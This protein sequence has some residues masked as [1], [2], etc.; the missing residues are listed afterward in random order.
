MKAKARPRALRVPG[1]GGGH[2]PRWCWASLDLAGSTCSS[3]SGFGC[4]IRVSHMALPG[5]G[6]PYRGWSSAGGQGDPGHPMS[7]ALNAPLEE[8][9]GELRDTSLPSTGALLSSR[10]LLGHH[11]GFTARCP[12]LPA[13]GA[14]ESRVTSQGEKCQT[15]P[16]L[17]GLWHRSSLR[18]LRG[19]VIKGV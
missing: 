7:L 13:P 16:F 2:K 14:W 9:D 1:P 11:C 5:L 10:L 8:L 12:A 15:L 18:C 6:A 19:E 17:P 4:I 3:P